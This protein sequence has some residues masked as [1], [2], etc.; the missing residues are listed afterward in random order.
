MLV[1]CPGLTQMPVRLTGAHPGGNVYDVVC[2]VEEGGSH[3]FSYSLPGRTGAQLSCMAHVSEE[4]AT[5]L[6]AE[7][8]QRLGRILLQNSDG[9]SRQVGGT[10]S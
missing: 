3:R 6:R 9:A 1:E 2:R 8:E 4:V 5:F 10:E 7:L